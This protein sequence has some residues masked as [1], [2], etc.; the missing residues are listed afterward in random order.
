MTGLT[1]LTG[2]E[3]I[4]KWARNYFSVW[5]HFDSS[6]PEI[7]ALLK[8]FRAI[9]SEANIFM[10]DTIRAIAL[11]FESIQNNNITMPHA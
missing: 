6:Q 10:L 2:F 1:I 8:E 3:N 7:S 11:I 4:S 9:I 5:L